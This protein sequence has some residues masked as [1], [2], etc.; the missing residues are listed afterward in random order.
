[1]HMDRQ[2]A[3]GQSC[4]ASSGFED[5]NFSEQELAWGNPGCPMCADKKKQ[6]VRWDMHGKDHGMVMTP[7]ARGY[8]SG[9]QP[10]HFAGHYARGAVDCMSHEGAAGC[11]GPH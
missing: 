7:D 1:M 11:P 9:F 5:N 6:T 10:Y 8:A 3:P 4:A 2:L